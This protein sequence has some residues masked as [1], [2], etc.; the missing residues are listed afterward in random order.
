MNRSRPAR[1]GWSWL[2]PA[3][4][5][6]AGL[7]IQS[8]TAIAPA[9]ATVETVEHWAPMPISAPAAR[10][11]SGWI[12]DLPHNRLVL[13]GGQITAG[14]QVTPLNDT[15][16][17]DLTTHTWEPLATF[18][19]LPPARY[20]HTVICDAPRHRMLVYGGLGVSGYLNDVWSLDL[21]TATWS[22]IVSSGEIPA[23][24]ARHN[25]VYDP[26][27]DRMVV[28]GGNEGTVMSDTLHALDLATLTWSRITPKQSAPT[29]R[30]A[31][32][33]VYNSISDRLVLFGGQDTSGLLSD[34]W[35]F[36]FP[37]STWNKLNPTGLYPTPRYDISAAYD[38][39]NNQV[40]IFGGSDL[41]QSNNDVFALSLAPPQ[42]WGK[43]VLSGTA[44]APRGQSAVLPVLL[45]NRLWL[46]GGESTDSTYFSDSF[47]LNVANTLWEAVPDSG[48]PPPI[49][50][51]CMAIDD[52]AHDRMVFF[53]G[54]TGL[55]QSAFN[56]T[57]V[58]DYGP[59]GLPALTWRKIVTV[60]YTPGRFGA[61]EFYDADYGPDHSQRMLVF[62]GGRN[63][64]SYTNDLWQLDLNSWTWSEIVTT[65]PPPI[66]TGQAAVYDEAHKRIV[67]FGGLTTPSERLNDT[68]I[69]DLASLAWTQVNTDPN[70][71]K[72]APRL[73]MAH[74]DDRLRNRMIIACGMDT[75]AAVHSPKTRMYNDAWALDY[76]TL[77]WTLLP[78]TGDPAPRFDVLGEVVEDQDRMYMFG[79]AVQDVIGDSNDLYYLDLLTHTWVLQSPDGTPAAKRNGYTM[80]WDAARRWLIPFSGTDGFVLLN[81]GGILYQTLAGGPQSPVG[82]PPVE[83]SAVPSSSRPGIGL[84]TR[85]NGI[86]FALR[87][88]HAGPAAL[89]VY[90]ATGRRVWSASVTLRGDTPAVARWDARGDGGM[91]TPAGIYLARLTTS[92]G[93]ATRKLVWLR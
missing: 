79:G 31:A 25:A 34:V 10:G 81:N 84:R 77:T 50:M 32:G 29:P 22:Q 87:S 88:P 35:V 85:A 20:R 82:P 83:P 80:V 9:R 41:T 8:T 65:N 57:W 78:T 59:V 91:T 21:D 2:S 24:R 47:A 42:V 90:S 66:R 63:D 62:S 3:V 93:S 70:A 44:P 73:R 26:L 54:W 12:A 5:A 45:N 14:G 68:W 56:E 37:D 53:G 55:D 38:S 36:N 40:L 28:F 92:D 16:R 74:A 17:F 72:P 89:V 13:F 48:N 39:L 1:A 6:L 61:S 11:G 67:M 75:L 60:G 46:S 18:G 43:L 76:N 51:A 19:T 23:A 4:V 7:V 86:D 52:I 33:M 58:M 27:R 30:Q 49:R 64:N 69:L 71:A 15:W